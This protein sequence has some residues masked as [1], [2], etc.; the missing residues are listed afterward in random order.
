MLGIE[1]CPYSVS[2]G[3]QHVLAQNH[4]A[5]VMLALGWF[6]TNFAI[7]MHGPFTVYMYYHILRTVFLWKYD[8][9]VHQ[10]QDLYGSMRYRYIK[11]DCMTTP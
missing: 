10:G 1:Y 3:K 6:C 9:N 7:V 11:L 2:N 4:T 5:W 8:P